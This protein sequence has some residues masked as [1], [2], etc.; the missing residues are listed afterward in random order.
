MEEVSMMSYIMSNWFSWLGMLVTIVGCGALIA[1]QAM[2]MQP[3]VEP[4]P[5]QENMYG[6]G[7][8]KKRKRKKYP[9]GGHVRKMYAKGGGIRKALH[10]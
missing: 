4:K 1:T 8:V 5:M 10:Y 9:G 7:M 2:A 6:G 3:R